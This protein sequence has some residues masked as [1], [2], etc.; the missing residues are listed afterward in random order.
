M[1]PDY[2][3]ELRPADA[4]TSA[5]VRWPTGGE[6][7]MPLVSL[8]SAFFDWQVKTRIAN[9]SFFRTGQGNHDFAVHAGYMAT[10]GA[11]D[12]FPLNAAAKGI[13]LLPR[14]D[15]DELTTQIETLVA[16]TKA[17]GDGATRDERLGFLL[18]L[19]DEVPLDDRVLATIEIYGQATW[20]NVLADPRCTVLFSSYRNTSYAVN[21]VVEVIRP[22]ARVYR[23]VVALHDLFHPPRGP[24]REYPAVY[25][26]WASEVWD[27]TPGPRAGDRLA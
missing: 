5:H 4:P 8:P 17:E 12:A 20:R 26:I 1:K 27:K 16:R 15:L 2:T 7:R 23:Y 13:G 10:S 9:L 11:G 21:G 14:D 22:G 24:R 18:R 19:Y 6:H 25:R 3:L